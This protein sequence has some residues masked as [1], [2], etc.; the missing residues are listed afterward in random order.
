MFLLRPATERDA[1]AIRALIRQVGINPTSL[2]WQRFWVA[3]DE[4]GQVIGCGQ[5]KP[6]GDGSHELASI[7]VQPVYRG[8]G[9]A[10]A[11]MERLL[12]TAPTPLYLTCRASLRPLYEKFGFGVLELAQMPS[13]FR[14]VWRVFR[15]LRRIFPDFEGLLVMRRP[16][17]D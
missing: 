15:W 1:R 16:P 9:V 10:R 5:I 13:Y 11:L 14:R 8:Q 12:T 7:A 6:H 2:N 17:P 4:A 3:V